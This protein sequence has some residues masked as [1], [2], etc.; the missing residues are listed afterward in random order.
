MN[1]N[2][3]KY[4]GT[5]LESRVSKAIDS[6]PVN[7]TGQVFYGKRNVSKKDGTYTATLWRVFF[8]LP[9]VPI[10]SYR[11]MHPE[12]LKYPSLLPRAFAPDEYINYDLKKIDLD[13]VQVISTL[14]KIW[15]PFALFLVI[16]LAYPFPV[17]YTLVGGSGIFAASELWKRT[18]WKKKIVASI[19]SKASSIEVPPQAPATSRQTAP[20][21]NKPA[22]LKIDI[23]LPQVVL[24]KIQPEILKEQ[25]AQ[26][27]ITPMSERAV[28]HLW[29]DLF[30]V[31]TS[32]VQG[33][34]GR[35][36]Q[37]K[38]KE[39]HAFEAFGYV[40]FMLF[41]VY[42]FLYAFLASSLPSDPYYNYISKAY[43]FLTQGH[44]LALV[45]AFVGIM[46]FLKNKYLGFFL[47][48]FAVFV[49][50]NLHVNLWSYLNSL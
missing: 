4:L 1:K 26:A 6:L 39:S 44:L 49:Y 46:M 12:E 7:I 41:P 33:Y 3:L 50:F 42:F 22:E 18:T 35:V 25:P 28:P 10:D 11:V 24:E 45:S 15:S 23:P 40:N 8:Y 38:T 34:S 29:D 9:L 43:V 27:R 19:Q 31:G 48:L 30:T 2:Q 13:W 5:D 14:F 17:L 47:I 21:S 16:L 20:A 36:K 32:R 37:V